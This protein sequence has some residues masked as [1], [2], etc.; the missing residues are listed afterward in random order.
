[1]RFPI[2]ARH[3]ECRGANNACVNSLY[4]GTNYTFLVLLFEGS[5]EVRRVIKKYNVLSVSK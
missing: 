4:P 3:S 1:M 2:L 5:V